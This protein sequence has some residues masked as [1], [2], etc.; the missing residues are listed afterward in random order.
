MDQFD[1]Y[2]EKILLDMTDAG[3]YGTDGPYDTSDARTP[4]ILGTYSRKGKVKKRKKR[5]KP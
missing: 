3:V 4:T 2:V 5:K 1:I